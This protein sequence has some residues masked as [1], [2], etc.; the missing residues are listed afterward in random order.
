MPR[1]SHTYS[2]LAPMRLLLPLALLCVLL[3]WV[4]PAC[5]SPNSENES[6]E[7]TSVGS[8]EQALNL[9]VDA[10]RQSSAGRQFVE[11][12]LE[13]LPFGK[14]APGNGDA[15]PLGVYTPS[16]VRLRGDSL[17]CVLD[18]G[19][20]Q[21][22]AFR[23]DGHPAATYGKGQ[24][25]GPGEFLNPVDFVVGA[26]GDVHVLD[27][28]NQKISAFDARGHHLGDH[29]IPRAQQLIRT[30]EGRLALMHLSSDHLFST[31][32][33][34]MET[35]DE[36]GVLIEDQRALGLIL[37]GFSTQKAS[38][39]AYVNAS[40]GDLAVFTHDGKLVHYTKGIDNQELPGLKRIEYE[41]QAGRALD[42]PDDAKQ[43]GPIITSTDN[44]LYYW[45]DPRSEPGYIDV[46]SVQ[47]GRYIRSLR[48]EDRCGP[49]AITRDELLA[50]CRGDLTLFRYEPDLTTH[51]S[52][53]DETPTELR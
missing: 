32:T 44:R 38:R 34:T 45:V 13:S 11:L 36:F 21:V 29:S 15:P 7:H 30:G 1:T 43:Y 47:D 26:E 50:T 53:K 2:C 3:S 6:G 19:S 4:A 37:H 20:Y 52:G 18:R 27:M 17:F 41:S 28:G 5:K 31:L 33:R 22:K 12:E 39:I 35:G 40:T 8:R 25:R 10:A 16:K 23:Y 49:L 48:F 9:Q 24:G 46:Y 14:T 42:L 51:L